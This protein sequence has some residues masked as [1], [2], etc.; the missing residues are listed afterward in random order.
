[1]S[2]FSNYPPG[3][4]GNEPEI[5]GDPAFEKYIEEKLPKTFDEQCAF[6]VEHHLIDSDESLSIPAHELETM[7]VEWLSEHYEPNEEESDWYE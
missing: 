3:V 7:I 2:N 5:A 1:M 4:S 6:A